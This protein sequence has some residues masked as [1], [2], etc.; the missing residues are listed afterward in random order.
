MVGVDGRDEQ[1][2]EEKIACDTE[3]SASITAPEPQIAPEYRCRIIPS[4]EGAK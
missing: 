4:P 3:C 2:Q 1:A